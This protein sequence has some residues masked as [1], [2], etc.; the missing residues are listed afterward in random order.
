MNLKDAFRCQNALSA[1]IRYGIGLLLQEN[2][3][4][5]V[6]ETLFRH[7]VVE[8][9]EDETV[10][11]QPETPYAGKAEAIVRFVLFLLAT[12]EQLAAAIRETKGKIPL[13]IDGETGLNTM[14]RDV[15]HALESMNGMQPSK[16]ILPKGG[17]C[18]RF[19]AEG[20]EVNYRVDVERETQLLFDK[21]FV[22]TELDALRKKIN[23]VSGEI[24]KCLIVSEVD[25]EPPFDTELSFLDALEWYGDS[26][27]K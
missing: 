4:V 11:T 26:T 17:L 1:Y 2:N 16:V 25:F 9:A 12:K 23:E 7:K 19:N 6:S 8:E 22:R 21:Q 14:R 5:S 24:D 27:G 18:Y 20:N 15:V 3:L 13:D 10:V